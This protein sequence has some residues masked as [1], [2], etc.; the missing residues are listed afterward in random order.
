MVSSAA[1]T[2]DE[3]LS[4][5]PADRAEVLRAIRRVVLDHLP[6]G[7][8][9][10]MEFGMISYHVPLERF[11]DT[12]NGRPLGY[13]AL[14]AQKRHVSIYLMGVYDEEVQREFADQW[15]ATGRKLDMGKACVR[16]RELDD[17]ALDVLGDWV[18]RW[19]V[20][21]FITAYRAGRE[22]S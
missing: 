2:P 14:A 22:R 3:Y 19:P 6:P 20:D 9:E 16:V 4:E 13:V 5:L 7:Y 10:G 1:A 17:V 11:P 18:A 12:Y 15:R 8:E 21:D